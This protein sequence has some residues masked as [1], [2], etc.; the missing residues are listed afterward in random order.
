MSKKRIIVS[1]GDKQLQSID[2]DGGY[3]ITVVDDEGYLKHYRNIGNGRFGDKF[4]IKGDIY[5][6]VAEHLVE[7]FDELRHINPSR[8]LFLE[9][10][11]FK[12]K[13]NTHRNNKW[14]AKISKASKQL[15]AMFGY[16]YVLTTRSYYLEHMDDAK[17]A[18]LVYHELRHIDKEGKLV[19]HDVEDWDNLIGTLGV[20]WSTKMANIADIL[21][22]DFKGWR[23]MS[24]TQISMFE[25]DNLVPL[26]AVK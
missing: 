21:S 1:E 2:F 20:D 26:K 16:E 5:G 19:N 10:T 18:A 13:D 3:N 22:D 14:K 15:E 11:D 12:E 25:G 6:K 17:V 24:K 4:W 7:K 9:D 8:I 23:D